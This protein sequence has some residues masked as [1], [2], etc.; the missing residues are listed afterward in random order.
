MRTRILSDLHLE[1]MTAEARKAFTESVPV[2]CDVLVLAGDV[3]TG[4]SLLGTLETFA[5]RFRHVVYV[6]GNHEFYGTAV[7]ARLDA[8]QS[9]RRPENFHWLENSSVVLDGQR[10]IGC[11][12]WFPHTPDADTGAL[13]DFWQIRDFVP[14]VYER[15]R[16]SV[17]F[18]EASVRFNDVVVTHH[19]PS[20]R[21][22]HRKYRGDPLNAFFVCDVEH[23]MRAKMPAVWIHGHTHET[24]DLV[25]EQTRIVCNP[26]GYAGHETNGLFDPT[27][28]IETPDW[29]ELEAEAESV[30][31]KCEEPKP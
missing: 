27:K 8:L 4:A 9:W 16:E 24:V 20:N 5:A 11:S 22:V 19:L 1:F 15:N 7:T 29:P 26:Y 10:F 25:V 13:S 14:W 6:L 30:E 18:L 3:D 2:D 23:V 31:D 21:C 12:L 17:A 28:T